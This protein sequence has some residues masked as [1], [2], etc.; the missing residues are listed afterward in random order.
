MREP[1]V[2]PEEFE[3]LETGEDMVC[4]E[5]PKVN[6]SPIM[7][8]PDAPLDGS[9]FQRDA[10]AHLDFNEITGVGGEARG[11]PDAP[12]AT[13]A[14]IV[15]V[16]AQMRESRA[17]RQVADWLGAIARLMLL[18][19]REHMQLPFMVKE[20][21]D[22][23]AAPTDPASVART[24][25]GWR[26]VKAEDLDE[27]DVDVKIDVAS[28]SPVAEDMQRAQWNVVLQLLTNPALVMILMTG[29]P[30]APTEPSPLLRKTLT[31]NG[32]T[33]DQEIREIWRVGQIVLQQLQMMQL[34]SMVGGK[35]GPGGGGG[36]SLPSTP[37][38]HTGMPAGLPAM[39]A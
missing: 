35:G 7:P 30:A 27:L 5:V 36:M 11:T 13:Q 23:F 34:A 24:A 25:Q 39:G 1:G 28:L 8:I 22:P 12:T 9:N 15:N 4:I 14:N 17:R 21:L 20:T 16:R 10:A 29:N 2:K 31:L 38:T 19:I 3:K 18:T 33:S 37:G 26:E 32:I 6:P